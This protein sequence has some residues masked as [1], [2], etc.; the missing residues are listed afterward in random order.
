MGRFISTVMDLECASLLAPWFGTACCA[1]GN[2]RSTLCPM[3]AAAAAAALRDC[4]LH[5]T[6]RTATVC[7][8]DWFG[9]VD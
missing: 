7:Y 5:K 4:K 1:E 8:S 3:N 9:I 2:A 6:V